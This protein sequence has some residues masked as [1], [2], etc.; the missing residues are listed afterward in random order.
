M[1]EQ[2]G[3]VVCD[4]CKTS[5]EIRAERSH[6]KFPQTI[7]QYVCKNCGAT[8]TIEIKLVVNLLET[9]QS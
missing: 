2:F 5:N 9:R 1:I 8:L 7:K 3:N 6:L 4:F